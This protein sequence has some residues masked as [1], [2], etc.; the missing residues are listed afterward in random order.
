MY[1]AHQRDAFDHTAMLI[2][3]MSSKEIHPY[4][5]NPYRRGDRR[6]DGELSAAEIEAWH[7]QLVKEGKVGQSC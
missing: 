3:S 7:Q 1:L 6:R 4:R 2:A 5:L